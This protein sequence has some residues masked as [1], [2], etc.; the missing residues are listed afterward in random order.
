MRAT[1]IYD[2]Y[3]AVL[4]SVR[5]FARGHGMREILPSPTATVF[6]FSP[7]R[8]YFLGDSQRPELM[9]PASNTLQKQVACGLLG[10]VFCIA[11]CFR[12]EP[13]DRSTLPIF[14]QIE[15]ELGEADEQSARAVALSLLHHVASDFPG[16]GRTEHLTSPAV[17]D[18]LDMDT[19]PRYD[20]YDD[21]LAREVDDGSAVWVLHLPD[22]P[23]LAVNRRIGETGLT[24]TFEFLLPEGF[25][26]ILSGGSRD[27]DMTRR[28]WTRA[29]QDPTDPPAPSSGFG[30]GL[31]RLVAWL[32]DCRDLS[33]IRLPHFDA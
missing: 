10:S 7:D 9:L 24:E 13:P 25:G 1:E 27:P 16:T 30:V 26:E 23:H 8:T 14:H 20:D 17:I 32:V 11:P 21:W 18:L 31:E 15:I 4:T 22:N 28:L 2:A 6:E 3:H 19:P 33:E 29:G 5:S 12:R